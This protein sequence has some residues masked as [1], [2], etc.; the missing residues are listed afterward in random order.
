MIR[1]YLDHCI[2]YLS[3]D[4]PRERSDPIEVRYL[5]SRIQTQE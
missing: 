2:E 1:D 5:V 4:K 3:Y